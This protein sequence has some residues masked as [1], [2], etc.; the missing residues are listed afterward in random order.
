MALFTYRCRSC[1]ASARRIQAAADPPTCAGCGKKMGRF[2]NPP[3][4][5]VKE[6]LDNGVMSRRV[7]RLA[8]AEELYHDRAVNDPR[9]KP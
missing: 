5:Q 6:V 1:G 9:L 3:K 4:A 7:E 8:D 2:E